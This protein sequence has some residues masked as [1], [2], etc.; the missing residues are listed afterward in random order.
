MAAAEAARA[1][2][3][4]LAVADKASPLFGVA[5][6]QVV[7]ADGKLAAK[8]DPAKTDGYA[9]VLGR[10]GRKEVAA[11]ASTGPADK[12]EKFSVLSTGAQFVEVKIDPDL[13]RVRV[14]RVVGVFDPGKVL[15]PRL[16]RSQFLGGIT[17]GLGAALLERTVYD[18]RGGSVVTPDLEG[19]LVPVNADAPEIDVSFI[20]EPDYA[21]NPTGGRGL[22][23]LGIT[24]IAAAV[25]NAVFHAT[26]KRVRHLPITVDHLL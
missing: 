10:A 25:A 6:D 24:G 4:K 19:Y 15:N 16:A 7:A 17:M 22:G 26:G 5:V 3:V 11:E 23:E 2:L 18:P 14:T 12:K 13:P 8:A 9:D 1:K 20:D 21:F